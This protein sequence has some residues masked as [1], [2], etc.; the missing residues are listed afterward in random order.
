M[1]GAHLVDVEAKANAMALE[2][3]HGFLLMRTPV[4]GH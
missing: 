1:F 4:S 2:R 3:R